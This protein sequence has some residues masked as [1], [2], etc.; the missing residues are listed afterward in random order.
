MRSLRSDSIASLLILGAG[1]FDGNPQFLAHSSADEAAY[2]VGLP[3]GCFH[4]F[5]K[6]GALWP[7]EE[8]QHLGLLAAVAGRGRALGAGTLTSRPRSLIGRLARALGRVS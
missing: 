4:N 7:L 8:P 1:R 2:R 6:G 5:A 3:S